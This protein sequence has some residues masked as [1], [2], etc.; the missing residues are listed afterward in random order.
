MSD[1]LALELARAMVERGRAAE[2]ERLAAQRRARNGVGVAV[3]SSGPPVSWAYDS[4]R[5]ALIFIDHERREGYG[6]PVLVLVKAGWN[7]Q[8]L[9]LLPRFEHGKAGS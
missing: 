8:G 5:Q 3:A 9:P 7:V 2:V 6:F 4:S 1:D